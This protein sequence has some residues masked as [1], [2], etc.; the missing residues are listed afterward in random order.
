MLKT[1][2]REG[3]DF[4]D[5]Q[6]EQRRQ[7]VD[8]RELQPIQKSKGNNGFKIYR[9]KIQIMVDYIMMIPFL[10]ILLARIGVFTLPKDKEV[11]FSRFIAPKASMVLVFYC[12]K[13]F[14]ITFLAKISGF[15]N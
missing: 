2:E 3:S 13:P 4:L 12:F 6:S 9:P 10:L 7:S 8:K 5:M 14:I 15:T 11:I 1:Y